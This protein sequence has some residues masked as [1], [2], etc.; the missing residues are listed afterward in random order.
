MGMTSDS[1]TVPGTAHE[2]AVPLFLPP[3]RVDP[4]RPPVPH[5]AFGCGIHRCLGAE[6]ARMELRS[7][8]PAEYRTL[9]PVHGV[10]S[11]PVTW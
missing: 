2:G 9:S 5:L 10:R 7:A 3:D 8:L 11:L 4:T 6:L 1:R